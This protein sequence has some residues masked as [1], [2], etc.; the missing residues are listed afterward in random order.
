MLEP[1]II[2][3]LYS[4]PQVLNVPIMMEHYSEF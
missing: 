4:F 3:G 1:Y 2:S